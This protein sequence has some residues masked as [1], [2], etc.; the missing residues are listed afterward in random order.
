MPPTSSPCASTREGAAGT[1]ASSHPPS[2]EGD[3]RPR[4]LNPAVRAQSKNAHSLS[5]ECPQGDSRPRGLN[6]AAQAV[7]SVCI[8]GSVRAQSKNAP[9]LSCKCSHR[10]LQLHCTCMSSFADPRSWTVQH[11]PRCDPSFLKLRVQSSIPSV[12]LCTSKLDGATSSE[13]RGSTVTPNLVVPPT[14]SH[15][16]PTYSRFDMA[17]LQYIQ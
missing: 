8:A 17:M 15:P 4:G 5:C 3:S 12:A 6:P 10:F 7:L 16:N 9:F 11:H 13:V 14:S 2:R 1:R